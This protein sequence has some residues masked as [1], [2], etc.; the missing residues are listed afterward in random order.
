MVVKT[1]HFQ[2]SQIP[3]FFTAGHLFQYFKTQVK[4]EGVPLLPPG[5]TTLP[6]LL[7]YTIL[8][9]LIID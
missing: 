7:F 5:S 4:G 1:P 6:P 8:A 2:F 3:L 9:Y